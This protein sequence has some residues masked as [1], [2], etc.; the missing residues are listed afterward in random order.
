MLAGLG[1][2]LRRGGSATA[3]RATIPSARAFR[4][5]VADST[6]LLPPP[7][8]QQGA[9]AVKEM[10]GLVAGKGDVVLSVKAAAVNFPDLLIVQGKYQFKPEGEFSP[11][12]EVAGIVKAVG[13]GVRGI[14]IGDH[15]IGSV[16][17][18]GFA[19][20]CAVPFKRV[21]PIPKT[22]PFPEAASVLMAYGTSHYALVDRA[23]L[24][25]GETVLIL[26][27]S[28][29][30]GL[31]AVQ[32]AKAMG[33]KVIAAAS[34]E[35]KLSLCKTH[36]ADVMVN[37]GRDGAD[38]KQALKE[39]CPQG[40][41]IVYDPVGGPYTEI[42]VRSMA[43]KGR[44]LIIGFAAGKIPEIPLNLC[45]LKGCSLV[46]V[47]WGQFTMQEPQTN[48]RYLTELMQLYAEGKIKPHVSKTYSLDQAIDAMNTMAER[49]VTGKV[50]L[51]P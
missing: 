28:G 10:K 37:Y 16:P 12:S 2:A 13:E 27:A 7:P 6:A 1:G 44:Y 42:A 3:R 46:G 48:V 9:L 47:F 21:I 14:N 19:E 49:K 11:G 33:A 8:F 20:E 32:L 51:V 29:G 35:E 34:S 24:Q 39:A 17:Y 5:V 38:F 15:A 22:M 4:A 41:D 43:W 31:A 30:V 36:G 25:A 40:V 26:G 45:L 23:K 50:V 18:G